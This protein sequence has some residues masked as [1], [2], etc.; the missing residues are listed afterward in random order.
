MRIRLSLAL[1]A[2]VFFTLTAAAS[3]AERVMVG[4]DIYVREGE[5]LD[6]VVCIGCNIHVEGTVGEAVAIGGRIVVEGEA[7]GDLV[8]IGGRVRIDGKVG[9]DVVSIGGG[10]EIDGSVGGDVVAF[11]GNVDLDGRADGDLLA[12]FGNIILADGAEVDGDAVAVAGRVQGADGA[13]IGGTIQS[14]GGTWR[15]IALPGIIVLLLLGAVV[16]L[17]ALPA[18]AA[19]THTLLGEERVSV[20][21]DTMSLRAG[22]CFVLGIAVWIGSIVAGIVLSIALFWVPGS[23]SLMSIAFLALAAVGYCGL[24][25]WIGRG[26]V[27]SGSPMGATVLGAILVTIVQAIPVLGWFIIFPI[28]GF[29]ALGS[30]AMSGVGTSVDWLMPRRETDPIPRPTAS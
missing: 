6:E 9:G 30:A 26:L 15:Q 5:N 10:V 14:G 28:F 27:A 11:A 22:M 25:H 8:A 16:F 3:A 29:M 1:L 12:V 24:S 21:A 19:L 17:I 20:L 18:V 2:A 23:E 7:T 13:K 4:E